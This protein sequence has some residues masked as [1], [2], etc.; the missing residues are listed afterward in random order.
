MGWEGEFYRYSAA[1]IH[2][3]LSISPNS[4]Q[5]PPPV[6]SDFQNPQIP[7][8]FSARLTLF[9]LILSAA[10]EN[11]GYNCVKIKD[12]ALKLRQISAPQ[13]RKF[14]EIFS[15]KPSNSPPLLTARSRDKGGGIRP[16]FGLIPLKLEPAKPQICFESLL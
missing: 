15:L 2:V 10:G 1:Q 12:F 3:E 14:W 9:L 13:A 4:C 11:F 8:K 7:P 5:I 16:E 6:K